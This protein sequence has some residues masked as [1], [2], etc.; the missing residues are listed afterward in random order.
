M[1]EGYLYTGIEGGD[2]IRISM[3]EDLLTVEWDTFVRGTPCLGKYQEHICGRPLGM[4]INHQTKELV[5][6]DASYGLYSINLKTKAKTTLVPFGTIVQGKPNL[7]FNSVAVAKD[8]S[9]YYTISST[10]FALGEAMFEVLSAGSGRLMKYD[11][12]TNSSTVLV[13]GMNSVNGVALSEREDYL[14]FSLVGRGVIHKLYLTGA[15]EHT[16]EVLLHTPG[17]PDN[18]KPNGKGGFLVAIVMPH[19]GRGKKFDPLRDFLLPNPKAARFLVRIL[20]YWLQVFEWLNKFV[21]EC[22]WLQKAAFWTGNFEATAGFADK[23]GLVLEVDGET[24]QVV[25]SWHH[26]T[27]DYGIVSEALKIGDYLYLGS[28]YNFGVRRAKY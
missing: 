7:G 19:V 6:A 4:A 26:T 3:S 21:C 22:V 2:I 13:D 1:H 14:L 9:I 18:I 20:Y 23:Y 15:K 12:A 11:P 8:G 27:G 17:S 25:Q 16:S 24:G 5:V 10:N 28:P